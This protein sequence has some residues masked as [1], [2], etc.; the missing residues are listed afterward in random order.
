M[1]YRR[2]ETDDIPTLL[3]FRK[4]QLVDEGQ[5]PKGNIDH[6]ITK[7]FEKSLAEGSM[8]QYLSIKDG[9]I[10]ATGG[11]HFYAYP[12][13]FMNP[14]GKIAYIACMYTLPEY[15]GKGIATAIMHILMDEAS[16]MGYDVI[17]LHASKLGRPVYQKLGFEGTPGF[18]TKR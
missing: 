16:L 2:A 13:S 12:P 1:V 7:F 5:P 15:R 14:T 17:R 4:Q 6:E 10:I 8:I 11:V 3:E 18:M 9:T